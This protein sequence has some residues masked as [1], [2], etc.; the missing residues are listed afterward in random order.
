ML[1]QRLKV[2]YVTRTFVNYSAILP[3]TQHAGYEWMLHT[4]MR[5][6]KAIFPRT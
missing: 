3:R 1:E 5:L 6:F 4:R 2:C